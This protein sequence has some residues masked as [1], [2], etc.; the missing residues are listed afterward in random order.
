MI[1]VE[2]LFPLVTSILDRRYMQK[3]IS[4]Q[5]RGESIIQILFTREQ[6]IA[7]LHKVAHHEHLFLHV[8][9]WAP[10]VILIAKENIASID[11]LVLHSNWFHKAPATFFC[12]HT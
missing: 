2:Y 7:Q 9:I 12:L 4:V 3:G 10:A 1:Q 11:P 8:M 5:Q 6:K